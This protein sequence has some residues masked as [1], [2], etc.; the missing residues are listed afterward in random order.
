MLTCAFE[1]A[2]FLKPFRQAGPEVLI[3][4]IPRGSNITVRIATGTSTPRTNVCWASS[5]AVVS[6]TPCIG[7]AYVELPPV[8]R[9]DKLLLTETDSCVGLRIKLSSKVEIDL[10]SINMC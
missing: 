10:N 7:M 2:I 8:H 1:K 6:S 5:L 3:N 4:V 9:K